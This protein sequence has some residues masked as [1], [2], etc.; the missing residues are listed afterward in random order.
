MP[1]SQDAICMKIGRGYIVKFKPINR[2][3]EDHVLQNNHVV[4]TNLSN[5]NS[6]RNAMNYINLV[7]VVNQ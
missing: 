7:L 5:R 6:E 1:L 4:N 2:E 3:Q